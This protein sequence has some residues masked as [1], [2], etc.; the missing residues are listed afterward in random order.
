M[1][2]PVFQKRATL[3]LARNTGNYSNL[4]TSILILA[5]SLGVVWSIAM[6]MSVCLSVSSHK[7][8]TSEPN[9]TEFL[10]FVAGGRG[11][12]LLWRRIVIRYVLPVFWMPSCFH[13][14]GQWARIKHDVMFRRAG[15]VSVPVGRETTTVLGWVGQNVEP[16]QNLM[17]TIDLFVFWMVGQ[18]VCQLFLIEWY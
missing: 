6:S 12:F 3:C 5:S 2:N 10:V 16:G 7:L 9:F 1:S 15:Q 18:K 8:K 14:M 13:T 11:S 4:T 17:L